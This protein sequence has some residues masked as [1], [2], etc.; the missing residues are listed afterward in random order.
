MRV[1]AQDASGDY[2]FGQGSSN[3][4]VNS[5][6]A[7]AQL[8]ETGLKLW[9]GEWFLNT[10]AGMPWASEVLGYNTQAFYDQAIQ[11]QIKSTVGVTGINSYNSSLNRATRVL[12]VNA[13]GQ[14]LYGSFA[15]STAIPV[16]VPPP[17]GGYGAGGYGQEGYGQ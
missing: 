7:V 17:G 6:Q 9:Q 12:T 15:I 4:L 10:S 3:F 5:A 8:V 16:P 14:S 13:N 2:T 11:A 1:R